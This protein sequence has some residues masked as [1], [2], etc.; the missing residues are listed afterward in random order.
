MERIFEH[1]NIYHVYGH[2]TDTAIIAGRLEA[3]RTCGLHNARIVGDFNTVPEE[4]E[5]IHQLCHERWERCH[6]PEL[7]TCRAPTAEVCTSIHVC[8]I[9]PSLA[10]YLMQRR[11]NK[12]L[13]KLSTVSTLP[14]TQASLQGQRA[15][16]R[17]P[18]SE[19]TVIRHI[20]QAPGV[21]QS[22]HV[23]VHAAVAELGGDATH[24]LQR[25]TPATVMAC[26]TFT[27]E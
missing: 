22:Y 2:P 14:D 27:A 17:N 11:G 19:Q 23:W 25:I 12:L 8:Y 21:E 6:N 10:V 24:A 1:L 20:Q 16:Q 4:L 5:F 9:S 26:S 18:T 7:V 15:A 3:L 13:P